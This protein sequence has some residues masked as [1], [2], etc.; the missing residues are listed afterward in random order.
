MINSNDCFLAFGR[1][2]E[3]SKRWLQSKVTAACGYSSEKLIDRLVQRL[4]ELSLTPYAVAVKAVCTAEKIGFP[5]EISRIQCGRASVEL[6]TGIVNVS[7][8]QLLSNHMDFLLH[9]GF[10]MGAILLPSRGAVI[11]EPVVLVFGVGVESLFSEGND[12]RFVTY[13][14]HG[15]IKPLA[16]GLKLFVQSSVLDAVSTCSEITYCSRPLIRLLRLSK[17]GCYG[18]LALAFKH[19][20]LLFGYAVSTTRVYALSLLGRDFAYTAI[21]NELDRRSLIG[22][23]IYTTSNYNSQPLWVR[24]LRN[25]KTHLVWY[26]QNFKP[27]AYVTDTIVA[28]FPSARWI[29]VDTHWVWTQAFASFL[30][31]MGHRGSIEVVGPIVWY[32]PEVKVPSRDT[33]SIVIFDI[34][35]FSDQVALEAGGYITNYNNANNLF[36]FIRTIISLKPRLEEV[37]ELPV[38]FKLKTKRGFHAKYDSEYFDYLNQL[39]TSGVITLVDHSSNIYSLIS[40]SHLAVVYPFSSPAYISETVNVPSIYYDPTGSIVPQSFGDNP[41]LVHFAN[42]PEDLLDIAIVSIRNVLGNYMVS[43]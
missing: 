31:T 21:S 41:S 42:C 23:V 16:K 38:T 29:R 11:H 43:I 37:F 19:L 8:R 7:L 32:L 10:C 12:G 14:R 2:V 34:S 26:A 24:G 15:P 5:A 3:N 9:W 18:R 40:S 39:H 1:E 17:L 6:G 27:I 22:G 4:I 13:C 35:P 30:R 25:S 20:L 33:I 36:N 28:E